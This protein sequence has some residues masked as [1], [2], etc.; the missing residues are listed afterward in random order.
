M[1]MLLMYLL[2]STKLENGHKKYSALVLKLCYH[3]GILLNRLKYYM[4][5]WIK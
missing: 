1:N 4:E 2:A 5:R 3:Y